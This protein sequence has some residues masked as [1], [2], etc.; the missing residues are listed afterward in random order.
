MSLLAGV[1]QGCVDLA[2]IAVVNL[3]G[4]WWTGGHWRSWGEREREGGK[5]GERI[6]RGG[7]RR[8]R[9]RV[10]GKERELSTCVLVNHNIRVVRYLLACTNTYLLNCEA[11]NWRG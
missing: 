11:W 9:E 1:V 8:E 10:G 7:G 2:G 4:V 6:K 5:E 3:G